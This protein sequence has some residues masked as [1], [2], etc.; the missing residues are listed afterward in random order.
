MEVLQ[1]YT[2]TKC[3]STDFPGGPVVTTLSYYCMG[4]IPGWGTM[5]PAQSMVWPKKRL[6]LC[7]VNFTSIKK[8]KK[9]TYLG[10]MLDPLICITLTFIMK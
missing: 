9:K 2:C 10:F 6:I 8:K 1:H 4:S 5:I 3:H 7:F